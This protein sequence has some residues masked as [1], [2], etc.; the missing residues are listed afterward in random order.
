MPISTYDSS[1]DMDWDL[2][3]TIVIISA[4]VIIFGSLGYL[5]LV[6]APV[7]KANIENLG[8]TELKEYIADKEKFWGYA[9]HRYTWTC[10]K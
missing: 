1:N 5:V 2:I 4:L 3:G 9:E 7:T 6:D 8:C 10:E